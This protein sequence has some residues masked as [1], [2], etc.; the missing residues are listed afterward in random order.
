[1]QL[2]AMDSI[3][4]YPDRILDDDF[5]EMMYGMVWH[6]IIGAALAMSGVSLVAA[7]L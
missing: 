4:A 6:N 2:E 7:Q 3:V 5:L 1:M